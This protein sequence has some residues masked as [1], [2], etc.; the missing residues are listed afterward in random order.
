MTEAF[1]DDQPKGNPHQSEGGLAPTGHAQRWP[2]KYLFQVDPYKKDPVPSVLNRGQHATE[3]TAIQDTADEPPN[4][5]EN[6]HRSE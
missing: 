1:S 6:S 5:N 4:P 3:A 2:T